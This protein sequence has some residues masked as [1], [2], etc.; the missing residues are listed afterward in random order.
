ML[1][2]TNSVS[3]EF[4]WEANARTQGRKLEAKTEAET[5]EVL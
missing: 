4:I 5:I 1:K 2:K 3:T